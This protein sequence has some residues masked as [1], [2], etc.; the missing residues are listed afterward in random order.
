MPARRHLQAIAS[1]GITLAPI[2]LPAHLQPT[3][4]GRRAAQEII[5]RVDQHAR[6]LALQSRQAHQATA[7]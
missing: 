4:I 7:P 6:E 3:L 5:E 2:I 1:V